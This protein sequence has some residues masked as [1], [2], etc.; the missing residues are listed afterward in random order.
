[1]PGFPQPLYPV[2]PPVGRHPVT[3]LPWPPQPPSAPQ[4]AVVLCTTLNHPT[5]P[6]FARIA[7]AGCRPPCRRGHHPITFPT[8]RSP[9]PSSTRALFSAYRSH[10]IGHR[11]AHGLQRSGL[12]S[13]GVAL[14]AAAVVAGDYDSAWV[15]V[16][17]QRGRR[18][19]R[20]YSCGSGVSLETAGTQFSAKRT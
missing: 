12:S 6:P 5:P 3:R 11:R 19:W 16:R 20:A 15:P 10:R 2:L 13:T 14:G 4:K 7:S 18:G 9:P 17:A 8:P 1:M